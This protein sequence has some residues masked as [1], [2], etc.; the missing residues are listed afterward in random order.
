M[1]KG[2]S[3]VIMVLAVEPQA[4]LLYVRTVYQTCPKL[5]LFTVI[6]NWTGS[7]IRWLPPAF[8]GKAWRLCRLWKEICVGH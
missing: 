4:R 8:M 2:M 6:V 3:L 1:S 5:E 7:S